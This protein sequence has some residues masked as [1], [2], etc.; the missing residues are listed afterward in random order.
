[1]RPAERVEDGQGVKVMPPVRY[2]SVAEGERGDV[3][4][5]SREMLLAEPGEADRPRLTFRF[6]EGRSSTAGH[7][8]AFSTAL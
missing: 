4:L 8:L 1:L 2:F 7:R 5:L 6:Q 3:A